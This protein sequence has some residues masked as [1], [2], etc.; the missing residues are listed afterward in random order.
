LIEIFFFEGIE[1]LFSATSTIDELDYFKHGQTLL[2]KIK[3]H[4]QTQLFK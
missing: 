2:V 1:N 4:G 3:K